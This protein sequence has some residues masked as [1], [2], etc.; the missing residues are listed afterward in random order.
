MNELLEE[1]KKE[2]GVGSSNPCAASSW[3]GGGKRAWPSRS[4]LE[5]GRCLHGQETW[6]LG[7]TPAPWLT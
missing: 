7:S 2:L 4:R 6:M 5:G 1:A 3:D